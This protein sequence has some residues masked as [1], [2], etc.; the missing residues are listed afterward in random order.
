MGEELFKIMD[1]MFFAVEDYCDD[2]SIRDDDDI[3]EVQLL[4][5][6]K[7]TLTDINELIEE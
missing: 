7:K 1:Y 6:A 5:A 3:D 4:N 2:E